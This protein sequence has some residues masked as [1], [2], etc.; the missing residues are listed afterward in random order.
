[1]GMSASQARFLSLT[2]RK[3]NTEYEGQQI[4]QQRTALSNESSNYYSKLTSMNV[5]TPP[6]STDYSKITYTFVNGTETNTIT[7]LVATRE[8]KETGIY[9]LNYTQQIP[10]DSMVVNGTAIV[11]RSPASG[12]TS[13]TYTL[14]NKE[15]DTAYNDPENIPDADSIRTHLKMSI[16]EEDVNTMTDDEVIKKAIVEAR[17]AQMAIEK[18]NSEDFRVIYRKSSATGTY[19]PV[20]ISQKELDNFD[21]NQKNGQSLG[22]LKIYE[23]GQSTETREF[24]NQDA[25]VEQDSSGR[26]ISIFIYDNYEQDPNAGTKYDLTTSTVSDEDGYNDAMNQYYYDKARYDQTVQEINAKIEV[27]QIQD[28]NLELKLKQ[29]DTEQNAIATEMDA[30]KKV[31]SK[32]VE[33][34]FK[35]FNG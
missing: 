27:I 11:T 25:R 31:I 15:L 32:N 17:Y 21:F 6:A 35:T 20:F 19:E 10:S 34:S 29:L 28:K 3:T 8:T 2:A 1:M 26:Y 4:N 12:A 23:Y 14:L 5:P 24:K 30:V 7:S 9:K 16:P 33:S 18:Y 22:G 13:F